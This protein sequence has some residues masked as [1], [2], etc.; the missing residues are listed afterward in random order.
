MFFH[1]HHFLTGRS[2]F[3]ARRVFIVDM[4]ATW[5]KLFMKNDMY[6][7]PALQALLSSVSNTLHTYAQIY[8]ILAWASVYFMALEIRL[9]NETGVYLGEASIRAYTCTIHVHVMFHNITIIAGKFAIE[10]FCIDVL[11]QV[12]CGLCST[13]CS[14]L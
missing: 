9:Q 3:P 14:T 7:L 8:L 11:F 5:L 2:T 12:C 1:Y 10:E 13:A 6:F 4:L